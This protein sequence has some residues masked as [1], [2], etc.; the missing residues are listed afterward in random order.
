MAAPMTPPAL[1]LASQNTPATA[2]ETHAAG[3]QR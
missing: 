1:V 2:R 3:A